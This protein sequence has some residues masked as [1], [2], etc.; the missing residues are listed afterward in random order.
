MYYTLAIV[1]LRLDSCINT[2]NMICHKKNG[3]K[4]PS[5]P[6]SMIKLCPMGHTKLPTFPKI[7]I[8]T[9]WW[10]SFHRIF[11]PWYMYMV[12]VLLWPYPWSVALHSPPYPCFPGIPLVLPAIRELVWSFWVQWMLC[13][14]TCDPWVPITDKKKQI[15]R[16]ISLQVAS[17]QTAEYPE[18]CFGSFS[19]K[20]GWISL[21]IG[22][23]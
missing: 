1:I 17:S 5:H 19:A 4:R 21:K 20:R 16:F 2:L 18:A 14:M 13:T 12:Q 9:F 8:W 11:F 23:V 6:I 7:Q 10:I 15:L 22:S 3:A